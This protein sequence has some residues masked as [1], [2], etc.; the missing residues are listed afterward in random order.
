METRLFFTRLSCMEHENRSGSA[1][2][3]DERRID[4]SQQPRKRGPD[5]RDPDGGL[6]AYQGPER[7]SGID[8][9][10]RG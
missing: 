2:S 1:E 4:F 9:R 3:T 10:A 8:R 6:F 5:R 7:R